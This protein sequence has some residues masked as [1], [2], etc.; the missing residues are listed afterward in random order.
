VSSPN[1]LIVHRGSGIYTNRA[2]ID[3]QPEATEVRAGPD[4]AEV[5]VVD[6]DPDTLACV[7]EVLASEGFRVTATGNGHAALA[8]LAQGYHPAAMLVDLRMPTMTGP[9]FLQAC[10]ADPM[11]ANIPAIITSCGFPSEYGAQDAGWFLQKP[12]SIERVVAMIGRL[13]Q[14][15][16]VMSR[17]GA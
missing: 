17:G 2:M 9:E 7:E 14:T 12:F 6:D 16:P 8:R 1:F 15:S 11:L 3:I 13:L 4:G 5:L 10:R